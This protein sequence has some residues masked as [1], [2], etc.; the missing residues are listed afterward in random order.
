MLKG[1]GLAA[2]AIRLFM[3]LIRAKVVDR[4]GIGSG[5]DAL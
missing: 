2:L 1:L 4:F 3:R 5:M